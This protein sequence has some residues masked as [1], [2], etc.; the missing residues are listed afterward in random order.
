MKCNI[1]LKPCPFCGGLA[2]VVR[3]LKRKH[4]GIEP[5]EWEV[6]E[7]YEAR[8]QA[9]CV[10]GCCPVM[11]ETIMAVTLEDAAELWNTRKESAL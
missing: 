1:E 4:G 3:V 8:Y 5:D 2:E 6:E 9:R 7:S 11:P 10:G